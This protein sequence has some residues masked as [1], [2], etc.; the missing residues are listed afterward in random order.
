MV[1]CLP[2]QSPHQHTDI[3]CCVTI[4]GYMHFR[5]SRI[6]AHYVR[7]GSQVAFDCFNMLYCSCVDRLCCWC[8]RL[9]W[10]DK[11]HMIEEGLDTIS[12]LP[13]VISCQWCCRRVIEV[14]CGRFTI[15]CRNQSNV[16]QLRKF[17][18][19]NAIRASFIEILAHRVHISS[20]HEWRLLW[21]GQDK[22][23][24]I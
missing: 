1:L 12:L 23:L 4:D 22:F 9:C 16:I 3:H 2:E 5:L 15:S 6:I 24:K 7:W 19:N 10:K 18:T 11:E 21:L 13:T 20:P 14:L 8:G 17:K